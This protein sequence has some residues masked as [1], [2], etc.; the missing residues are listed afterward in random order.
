MRIKVENSLKA[1]VLNDSLLQA[2]KQRMPVV[3]F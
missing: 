3:V 2:E 1:V